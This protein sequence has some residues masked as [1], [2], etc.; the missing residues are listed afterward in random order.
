MGAIEALYKNAKC[1]DEV[2]EYL[3]TIEYHYCICGE[4]YKGRQLIAPNC[5][6]HDIKNEL[7]E[8][9]MQ[10]APAN[11]GTAGHQPKGESK[12]CEKHFWQ[13]AGKI[14]KCR[15]CGLEERQ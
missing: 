10:Y 11:I 8:L 12:P 14:M 3:K 4:E 13:Y 15:C 2:L 5:V 9:I 1:I 6:A 7:E